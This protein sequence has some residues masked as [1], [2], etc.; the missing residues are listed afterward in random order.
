[1]GWLMRPVM[2][3]MCTFESL[4]DGTLDLSHIALMNDALDVRAENAWRAQDAMSRRR[5]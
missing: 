5:Q 3:G 4:L 2:E 1:M